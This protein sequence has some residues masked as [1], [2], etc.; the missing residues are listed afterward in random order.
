MGCLYQKDERALPGNLLNRI[1]RFFLSYPK[2]SV[3]HYFTTSLSLSS[4]FIELTILTL[5]YLIEILCVKYE[6]GSQLIN[7]TYIN[8][9]L[10]MVKLLPK[11]LFF[12]P[13]LALTGAWRVHETSRFTSVS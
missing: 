11:S 5:V 3:F 7:I 13:F 9:S 12:I 10:Q 6:V 1:Y 4:L 2:C 8:F